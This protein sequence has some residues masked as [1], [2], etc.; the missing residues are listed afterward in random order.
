ML[1][2][3]FKYAS[4]ESKAIEIRHFQERFVPGLLQT[5]E[6]AAALHNAAADRG[7]ISQSQ[8]EERTAFVVSRRRLLTRTDAPHFHFIL[9]ESC[10]H[11]RIGGDA[12]TNAQ[13]QRL[14][15]LAK[16][17]N[18]TLQVFPFTRGEECPFA[19][20]AIMLTLPDHSTMLYSESKLGALFSKDPDEVRRWERDWRHLRNSALSLTDTLSAIQAKRSL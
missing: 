14:D 15:D 8:A 17:P 1:K 20:S 9:D 5:Q 6:Y 7:E 2:G 10:V 16:L 12:V 3:F 13:L 18:V 4:Y 11:T 19:W